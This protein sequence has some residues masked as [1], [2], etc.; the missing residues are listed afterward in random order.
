MFPIVYVPAVAPD[1]LTEAL[2]MS[3]L[4]DA[5]RAPADARKPR[6]PI[7]ELKV[8]TADCKL[9]RAVTSLFSVA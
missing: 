1:P 4:D 9:V 7:V 8:L 2:T 5:D 3:L 6:E